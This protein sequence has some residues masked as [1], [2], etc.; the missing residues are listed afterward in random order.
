MKSRDKNEY[1]K[2][3]KDIY[4]YLT[5]QNFKPKLNV[6]DNECSQ[7]VKG[8]LKKEQGTKIQFVKP[9]IH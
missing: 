3:F 1:H 8:Y 7:I 4:E 9:N 5:Q 2:A 6:M